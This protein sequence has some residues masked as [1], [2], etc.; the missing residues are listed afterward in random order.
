M[1][2]EIVLKEE[3]FK[4]IGACF[5]I[6]KQKGA[7]FLEDVYQECLAIEFGL[8]GIPFIEKPRLALAYKGHVLRQVYVPDFFCYDSIVVEIKAMKSLVDEHRAQTINYLRA[9]EKRLALLV[10][11]GHYP[12]LQQERFV[13]QLAG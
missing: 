8:R 4:I 13:N 5:E 3:S 10:N 9:T 2:A 1:G 7:G 6:Y 12:M 11:F